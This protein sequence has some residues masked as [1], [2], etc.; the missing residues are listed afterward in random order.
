MVLIIGCGY[1]GTEVGLLLKEDHS[2][3]VTT[4]SEKRLEELGTLFPLVSSL[5]INDVDALKTLIDEHEILVLTLAAKD[6]HSYENTYLKAALHLKKALENNASVKQILY[7]SSS[8]VYGDHQGSLVTEESSLLGSTEQSRI[9]IETESILLSLT[10]PGRTVCIFRVSEIYG[11]SRDFKKRVE[12]LQGR[13]APG[14]GSQITNII[15][16]ADVAHAIVFAI[17]HSLNGIYNLCND[18]HISRKEL[19]DRIS[20]IYHLPSV[21]W[22]PHLTSIHSGRRVLSNE[23]IKKRGFSFLYPKE[24]SQKK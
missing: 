13:K 12:S 23:K 19:Y 2:L 21:E 14:D 9:L 22:D 16:V 18:E 20:K 5:D 24:S 3:V 7:T 17:K 10:K 15:H 4:R 11:P 8:S 1:V 6:V